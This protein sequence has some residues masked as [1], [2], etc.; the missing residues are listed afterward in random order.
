MGGSSVSGAPERHFSGICAVAKLRKKN[1]KIFSQ[2]SLQRP[3]VDPPLVVFY[4]M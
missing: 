1:N 4:F 3:V 2:H